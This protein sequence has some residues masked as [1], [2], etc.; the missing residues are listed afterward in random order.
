MTAEAR[1]E[2]GIGDNLLR[3]SVG[4]EAVADIIADLQ[5]ALAA[6]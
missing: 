3:V 4:L 2:A 5:K 1:T 6:V